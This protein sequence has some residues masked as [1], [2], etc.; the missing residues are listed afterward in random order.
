MKLEL[1]GLPHMIEL[2]FLQEGA[3][4]LLHGLPGD[5]LEVAKQL[6]VLSGSQVPPEYVV[7]GAH[8]QHVANGVQV[9]CDG[10]AVEIGIS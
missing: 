9:L 5:T 1:Q 8:T 4:L 2:H 7:L 10:E 3:D 6:H